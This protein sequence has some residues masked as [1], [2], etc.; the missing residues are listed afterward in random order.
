M[1]NETATIWIRVGATRASSLTIGGIYRQHQILG[2]ADRETSSLELQRQQETRWTKVINSWTK[3]ARN[4]R[5]VVIGDLNL[6]HLKWATP[7]LHLEKMVDQVKESIETAGFQQHIR[8]HT[9]TWRTHSDSLLDQIWSN[10]GQR[11]IN[12]VNIVRGASD[13]NVVGITIAMK[14]IKTGGDNC[15]KRVWK[16]FNAARC[17]QK[18]KDANWDEVMNST[19]VNVANSILEEGI[20]RII[21]TEAPLK[22]VQ[23]RTRY[24]NWISLETKTEMLI[25]DMARETAKLTDNEADWQTYR[26]RR[27]DCTKLQKAD[28]NKYL[29]ETYKNI[30]DEKDSGRLFST[31]RRLLNWQPAGPP[32]SFL[33]DGRLTS[34]QQ[35]VADIQVNYYA[36]KLEKIRNQLPRVNIDPLA[37]LRKAH[38]RWIP[39]SKPEFNLRSATTKD[40]SQMIKRMKNSH[41]FGHDKIDAFIIKI[42]APALILPITHV[43]NLSLGTS[44]FPAKWKLARIVPLL[45]SS[46]MDKFNPSSYRPHQLAANFVQTHRKGNSN[47]TAKLF[48]KNQP[49]SI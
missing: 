2:Q 42:G 5:C 39:P 4:S 13:H 11:I 17:L 21:E 33:L 27:N 30:E 7:E 25:R 8:G 36:N 28:K 1:D 16:N 38:Q 44:H 26:N 40:V 49:V 43:I 6:D 46:D 32:K 19:N 12:T 14:D 34:K 23:V 10:C 24:K 35:Q 9:R 22:T 48:G 47:P 20:C 41:A 29:L 45:K 37:T 31:T 15:R 3:A 18:F